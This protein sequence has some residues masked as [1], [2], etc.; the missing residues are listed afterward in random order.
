MTTTSP[1]L[2]LAASL[3]TV[4]L[5]TACSDRGTHTLAIEGSEAVTAGLATDD[6]WTISVTEL[7]VVVHDPGL[8]ERTDNLPTWVREYGV[9][10]WDATMAVEEGDEISRRIRSTRYDGADFRV[11]PASASGYDAVAGN[12]DD[13][14]VD[15]A[16]EG[17]WSIHLI[18]SASDS[19][20]TIEFDWA[21]ATDSF[22]RCK[23]EGDEALVLGAEGEEATVIEI[24]GEALFTND[25][26]ESSFAAIAAADGDADGMVTQAE[27]ESA[28]LWD[29]LE[30]ASMRVG[31]IRGAGACPL[32]EE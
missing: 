20:Q 31:G 11:A 18:G 4:G 26:G 1:R 6:G 17:D 28:G 32:V 13:A 21:F 3:L 9:T 25:A 27:L 22:Y 23:F 2:V 29:A 5:A 14:V 10:V 24:L 19:M 30:S 15:A 16:V 12:V 8:I 7:H